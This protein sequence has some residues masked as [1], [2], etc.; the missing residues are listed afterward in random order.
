MAT[1]FINQTRLITVIK[2]GVEMN[3]TKRN[4]KL[5]HGGGDIVRVEDYDSLVIE[6]D[7]N[8]VTSPN[9]T[10]GTELLTTLRGWLQS[11]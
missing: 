6:V 5:H 3:F 1:E 9:V 7:F 4:V 8:D 11:A 10:S 2:D